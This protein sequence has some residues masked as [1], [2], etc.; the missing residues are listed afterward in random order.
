M[1]ALR[2]G[3]VAAALLLD[4]LFGEP[5]EALHPTVWVGSAISAFEG[6]AL[7]SK[8]PGARYLSGIV[9]ALFLPALVYIALRRL[10]DLTPRRPRWI[11]EVALISTA[12]SM[13][14]LGE[15]AAAVER[16][17][18]AGDLEQARASAAK[19]VGRDTASLSAPEVARAAVES[20]AENTSDGV[21]APMLYG[22]L[23]GGPGALAYRAVNTLDSMVGYRM[24]PYAELGWASARLDD[25]ANLAPARL[26][27]L[28][29][30]GV[31]GCPLHTLGI[32]R[33][34]GPLTR[35]PNA[36][37]AEAAFAGALGSRLGGSNSYGGVIREGPPLGEG[38]P[39]GPG[40][41]RHSVRLMRRCCALFAAAVVLVGRGLRG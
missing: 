21:V 40:E 24:H 22:L 25:L 8:N 20:V 41:I 31:S 6:V 23:F 17:L 4:V 19:M 10:V 33:R 13:R 18:R 28:L 11:L 5:P 30:A 7:E 26:T 36:G 15:A 35:S 12:I 16:G 27:A 37:W 14:G 32:A 34:Y 3:E 9:L 29:V 38:A 1:R 39:P 2:G